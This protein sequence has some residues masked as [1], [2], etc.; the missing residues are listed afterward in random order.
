VQ[1]EEDG[2][3]FDGQWVLPRSPSF[4]LFFVTLEPRVE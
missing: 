1:T 3:V 4:S 2:E